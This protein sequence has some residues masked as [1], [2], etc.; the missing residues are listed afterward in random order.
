MG[1]FGKGVHGDSSG[2]AWA[3]NSSGLRMEFDGCPG[4]CGVNL[5][6][7]ADCRSGGYIGGME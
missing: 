5:N 7:S 3:F 2:K 1:S 6:G 4:A